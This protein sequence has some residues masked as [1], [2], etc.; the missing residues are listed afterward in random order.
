MSIILNETMTEVRNHFAINRSTGSLHGSESGLFTLADG[1]IAVKNE[2]VV[3]Q[4]IALQGSVLNDGVYHVEGFEDGVISLIASAESFPAWVRPT[5]ALDAY[6]TGDK[7][8]HNSLHWVSLQNIN[9]IEPGWAG[10]TGDWWEVIPGSE[11][12]NP[13]FDEEW[14]GTIYSLRVPFDFLQLVR[15]IE[16]FMESSS[17]QASNIVSASF[18]I[19]ATS[20][21][22]D[23][24]GVRAGWQTVF[25]NE[26]HKYRRHTPDI[27]L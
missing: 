14:M 23:A 9:I 18:G 20:W 3:G 11:I 25:R 22:T 16:A 21:G 24:N 17:G 6:N 5:G 7:V 2:Y 8:T 15:R 19:Q 26:L 27:I 12:Q 4:Y 13:F 10:T 1:K